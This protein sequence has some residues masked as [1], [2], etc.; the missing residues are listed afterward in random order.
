MDTSCL[1]YRLHVL[2]ITLLFH[3]FT[4][5]GEKRIGNARD[6]GGSFLGIGRLYILELIHVDS[7]SDDVEWIVKL[8]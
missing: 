4:G 8:C 5:R 1:D 3:D 2:H 7:C 6:I